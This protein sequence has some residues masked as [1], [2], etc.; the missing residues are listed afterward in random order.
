MAVTALASF[1]MDPQSLLVCVNKAASILPALSQGARF[2]VTLLGCGHTDVVKAFFR[3]PGGRPRFEH[4]GWRLQPG[5]LPILEDAV[6]NLACMVEATLAYGTHRV[7]IGRVLASVTGPA[8][9]SLIYHDSD[10]L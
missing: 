9:P 7:I 1:S 8:V 2:A 10:F 6:A 4:P 5:E 3:K